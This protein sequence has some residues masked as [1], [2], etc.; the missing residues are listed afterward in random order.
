MV[1]IILSKTQFDVFEMLVLDRT[2]S[3]KGGRPSIDKR[4]ALAGIFWV[5][6]NGAKWKDLP[7]RFG[8]K[9]SVDRWFLR[10]VK[11]SV[12]TISCAQWDAWLKRK[13]DLGSMN[14]LSMEL[15]PKPKAVARVSAST[16]SER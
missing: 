15:L 3:P 8:S 9:S 4:R 10:W 6:E 5:L 16:H 7:K 11:A 1:M 2:V 13:V 12:L 14:T